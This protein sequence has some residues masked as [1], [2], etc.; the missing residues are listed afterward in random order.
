MTISENTSFNLLNHDFFYSKMNDVLV[1]KKKIEN[2]EYPFFI[3]LYTAILLRMWHLVG[4]VNFRFA[5]FVKFM[6]VTALHNF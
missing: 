1:F 2:N 5:K 6:L 4:D 3:F